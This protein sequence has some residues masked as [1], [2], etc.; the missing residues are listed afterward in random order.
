M[1]PPP[2]AEAPKFNIKLYERPGFTEDEIREIKEAFDVFDVD[3]GGKIDLGEL[4]A[5]M[6]SLGFDIDRNLIEDLLVKGDTGDQDRQID[7]TEFLNLMTLSQ[8]EFR[9]KS[10]LQE[11]YELFDKE[12]TGITLEVLK[13]ICKDVGEIIDDTELQEM[14]LRADFDQDRVVKFD[15]FYQIITYEARKKK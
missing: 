15:D 13:N 10:H 9:T 5:T 1:N 2:P 11:V 6:V 14:I 12:K 3:G 7:F 8:Q 4:Q